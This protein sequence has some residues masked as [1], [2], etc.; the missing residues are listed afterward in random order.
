M[1]HWMETFEITKTFY[2]TKIEW[3]W[4]SS[5]EIEWI[6]LS[7]YGTSSRPFNFSHQKV[8]QNIAK[9][10][11][12]GHSEAEDPGSGPETLGNSS[13]GVSWGI[14]QWTFLEN[15]KLPTQDV[16]FE[17]E[18][19]VKPLNFRVYH[20]LSWLR[21]TICH[22][23][24][25]NKQVPDKPGQTLLLGPLDLSIGN[26]SAEWLRI[27]QNIPFG[28]LRPSHPKTWSSSFIIALFGPENDSFHPRISSPIENFQGGILP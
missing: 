26:S 2:I 24:G 4:W 19:G 5:I 6:E 7:F 16:I 15:L 9:W 14:G 28:K 11:H 18:N 21:T 22:L 25:R 12:W 13:W 17:F 1:H 3:P 23:K 8:A 27:C 10:F 20:G